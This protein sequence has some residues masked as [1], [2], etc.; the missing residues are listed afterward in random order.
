M[1][2]TMKKK[3]LVQ[4]LLNLFPLR[5]TILMESIP[6][7]SDNTKAVFDEMIKRELNKK[8]KFRWIVGSINNSLPKIPNVY[9]VQEDSKLKYLYRITSKY[10][11]CCNGMLNSVRKNQFS[12]YLGHG[13]SVKRVH[14]YYNLSDDTDF[15][16]ATG[17]G[18]VDICA[19]ELNY[20]NKEKIIPLGYP[21]NDI[22]TKANLDL[23]ALFPDRDFEK[24]LVW[25]PTFRQ[26]RGG[27]MTG[28][29]K[30]LPIIHNREQAEQLNAFAAENKIL[31]V[32]KPHF[33]QDV[34]Y[35]KDYNM[36]HIV[37]INDRFFV[38]NGISSYEFVGSCDGLITDYSSIYFDYLLCDKPIAL[39]WEDLEE[40]K[41]DPG[42]ALG[43]EEFLNGGEQIYTLDEFKEFL[44]R[45]AENKD[46]LKDIRSEINAKI[47]YST[48]G[49]NAE[50]VVDFI[51][52][53]AKM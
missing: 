25:Y 21:R 4:F 48:D 42:L 14:D 49:K 43:V 2:R 27:R 28:S 50:R 36:T 15:C 29:A 13:T 45:V 30:A 37:F 34:S 40:Y 5:K 3:P 39:L 11:I 1:L 35:I 18:A 17:E 22:L 16:L 47:N 10:L 38:D 32:L 12:M 20:P 41:K 7:L 53:K 9:Y 24:V 8:Y 51:M 31:L 44:K 23:K 19:Y 46:L 33:A 52:E 6:D 26:H